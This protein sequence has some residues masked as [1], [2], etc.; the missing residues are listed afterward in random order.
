MAYRLI[1][2]ISLRLLGKLENNFYHCYSRCVRQ[3]YL[4]G[5]NELTGQDFEHR[6]GWIESRL[7]ELS[8]VFSVRLWS[9]AV[10]SN[11]YH[12]V[13]EVCAETTETWDSAEILSRWSQVFPEDTKPSSA[14]PADLILFVNI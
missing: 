4:C 14:K 9:Y 10:M 3:N 6:K 7:H 1:R 12:V 2:R 8:T 13:V 11:H 5:V